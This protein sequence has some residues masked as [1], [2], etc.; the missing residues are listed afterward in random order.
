MRTW[1]VLAVAIA[2]AVWATAAQAGAP[3]PFADP[4]RGRFDGRPPRKVQRTLHLKPGDKASFLIVVA[5]GKPGRVPPRAAMSLHVEW[6]TKRGAKMHSGSFPCRAVCGWIFEAPAAKDA[7]GA[8]DYE[9]TIKD[10]S[11]EGAAP[12]F[13]W[14]VTVKR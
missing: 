5:G 7:V 12:P 1:L 13:D 4:E 11:P 9:L 8:G 14:L 6:R 3:K 2:T 10:D